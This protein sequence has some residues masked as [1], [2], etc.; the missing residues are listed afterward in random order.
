MS[1][2]PR[3]WLLLLATVLLTAGL[4][5]PAAAQAD[6]RTRS[7]RAG[8]VTSVPNHSDV[9][10][11]TAEPGRREGD[12]VSTTVRHRRHSVLVVARYRE[13]SRG[14]RATSFFVLRTDRHRT[15]QVAVFV[16]GDDPQGD[17][18]F[19]SRGGSTL[20]CPGVRHAVD[21]ATDVARVL[22][23]RA[24]LGR[25][26]WVRAKVATE[27]V[28]EAKVYEDHAQGRGQKAWRFGPRV[29]R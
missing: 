3:P 11:R 8:D 27:T 28:T 7:D 26:R 4:L 25:P 14:V 13:L 5:A 12:L 10:D 22:V 6:S 15:R 29:R 2:V 17:A 20:P 23:P 21:Y 1:D 19:M 24:C 18:Y 9:E 16:S